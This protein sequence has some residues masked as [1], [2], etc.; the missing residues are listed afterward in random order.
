MTAQIEGFAARY[1][2]VWVVVT[3]RVIGYRREM[4]DKAGF[5][6]WMLQDL[7]IDQIRDFTAGWYARSCSGDMMQA[8]RLRDRLLTAVTARS[9]L[10][11]S[12][13]PTH[14]YDS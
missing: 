11:R 3:T 12:V 10:G 14:R 9:D 5:G 7:D 2:Q 13:A 4:L 1:P 6:H 8:V